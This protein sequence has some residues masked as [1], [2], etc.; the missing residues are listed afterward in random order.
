MS[1][2][3]QLRENKQNNNKI[4]HTIAKGRNCEGSL[5]I[6]IEKKENSQF[7]KISS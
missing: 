7:E 5:Y 3:I 4:F 2:K 6:V 1:K